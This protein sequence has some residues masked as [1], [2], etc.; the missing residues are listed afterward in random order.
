[1]NTTRSICLIVIIEVYMMISRIT[2]TT[3]KPHIII[4][5]SDDMVRH[6]WNYHTF[7][8]AFSSSYILARVLMMLDLTDRTKFRH[9]TLMLS[10]HS[11]SIWIVIMWRPCVLHLV[12]PL[13]PESIRP[14]LACS[15]SSYHP[16]NHGVWG[17]IRSFYPSIWRRLATARISL[18]NGISDSI[19][20][21][22]LHAGVDLIRTSV[23]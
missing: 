22:T 11:A 6:F 19:R 12:L 8:Y 2:A 15:I 21:A 17:L 5:M 10:L 16:S 7:L 14:I 1:M 18:E 4:I 9:L 23:I 13:W 20:N 3:T